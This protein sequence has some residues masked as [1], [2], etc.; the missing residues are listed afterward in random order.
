MS[1]FE[2]KGSLAQR[3]YR[4]K[5][6]SSLCPKATRGIT[7]EKL[8]ADVFSVVEKNALAE[9]RANAA[10]SGQLFPTRERDDAG[11]MVTTWE[12]DPRV[13]MSPFMAVSAISRLNMQVDTHE[14]TIRIK[15]GQRVVVV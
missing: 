12:G 7:L 8:P 11:R 3:Q 1:F 4:L 6:M 5:Q 2:P 9:A 13:W 10:T 14:E 15:N